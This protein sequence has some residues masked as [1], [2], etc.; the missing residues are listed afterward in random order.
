M[1]FALSIALM[2]VVGCEESHYLSD[3]CIADRYSCRAEDNNSLYQCRYDETG[4]YTRLEKVSEIE[5][6]RLCQDEACGVCIKKLNNCVVGELTCMEHRLW[7]CQI[8][9]PVNN[10]SRLN[11][12]DY[13]CEADCKE[14]EQVM[15]QRCPVESYACYT[16]QDNREYVYKCST[17]TG[18]VP[19]VDIWKKTDVCSAECSQCDSE[20]CKK[21]LLDINHPCDKDTQ[22]YNG[23]ECADIDANRNHMHDYYETAVN[24]GKDCRYYS[25]C[26]SAPSKG[27]GFCDSFIGYKCSTK[28]TS[29]EQCIPYTVIDGEQYKNICRPDG[30]CAPDTFISVWDLTDIVDNSENSLIINLYLSNNDECIL[31]NNVEID[32]GDGSIQDHNTIECANGTITHKYSKPDKYVVKLKGSLTL[33]NHNIHETTYRILEVKSFGQIGIG[34]GVF[35]N[36]PDNISFSKVDIPDSSLL[37]DMLNLFFSSNFNQNIGNWDTSNVTNMSRVFFKANQ[38][39]SPIGNWDT[40]RVTSMRSMF[41]DAI[42]FNQGIGRWNTSSVNSMDRMFFNVKK[43]NQDIGQWNTSNVTSMI[44]MFN[45]AAS[46]NQDI[47]DWNTSNVTNMNGMFS[48]ATSF[49]QDIGD[50]NTSNVTDM[51]FM[52]YKATSFNQDIGDWNTSNV[53]DMNSMFY[54]AT[55]FN[56]DIG[57]WNTS[58]VTVMN[59]MFNEA[60]VFN[61]DIGRWNVSNVYSFN[62]MFY[63]ADHFLQDSIKNWIFSDY[64]KSLKDNPTP[65]SNMFTN[66]GLAEENKV[67]DI[68]NHWITN[69]MIPAAFIDTFGVKCSNSSPNE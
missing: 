46:F 60:T 29:D 61:W 63:N 14:C 44:Y 51:S 25:D 17:N 36:S 66:S 5:T 15:R 9:D 39:N 24:Q 18:V 12:V 58:N 32:W 42:S 49:N 45:G 57:D 52:F 1:L 26:D 62:S 69:N 37:S 59:S 50:W 64:I 16:G 31:N 11:V 48:E 33:L 4:K 47:G 53:T 6:N 10:I 65:I 68:V 22:Y 20:N 54:E 56:Q 2:V 41:E 40:H 30:R 28:C 34:S 38:F 3:E 35:A 43:F 7:E 19:P 13:G 23:S 27:D 21:C 8:I 55:S 67:C